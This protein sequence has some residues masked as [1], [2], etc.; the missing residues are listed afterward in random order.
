M[1]SLMLA[2]VSDVF[3]AALAIDHGVGWI[4][5]KDPRRGALGA[6]QAAEIGAIVQHV[7]GRLPVSATIGDCWDTPEVV[8]A[9][10]EHVAETAVDYIKVGLNLRKPKKHVSVLERCAA[11]GHRLIVVCMAEYPPDEGAIRAIAAVGTAG[12]M[13]D[14][15]DKSGP[16]LTGLLEIGQIEKFV[17]LGRELGL[18]TGLAGR[19]HLADIPTLLPVGADYLGFR[20]ALCDESRRERRLSADAVARVQAA[21]R[22]EIIVNPQ[23]DSE[24]A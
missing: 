14:T 16:G 1:M 21:M 6:L 8:P 4:D 23:D 5:I 20:S 11:R 18:L 7:R 24:V 9:R 3:E 22:A 12:I 17:A 15:A 2:S 13:L 19:L 10:V